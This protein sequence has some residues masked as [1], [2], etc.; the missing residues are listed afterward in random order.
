MRSWGEAETSAA[1]GAV[2][3]YPGDTPIR[4]SYVE[5]TEAMGSGL[6]VESSMARA[7][8]KPGQSQGW[9][10]VLPPL[11]SHPRLRLHFL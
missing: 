3:T 6:R 5:R 8:Q 7:R 1:D 10:G 2:D 11:P 4:A 9:T